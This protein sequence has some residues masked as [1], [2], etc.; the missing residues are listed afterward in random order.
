MGVRFPP[1]YHADFL[2]VASLPAWM[3]LTRSGT[4]TAF[5]S[6]GVLASVSADTPR[7]DY[8]PSTSTLRGLLLEPARTQVAVYTHDF[9][10]V[11]YWSESTSGAGTITRTANSGVAPDGTTTAALLEFYRA[12]ATEGARIYQTFTTTTAAWTGSYYVKA[13][14]AGDIGREL[15]IVAY[16]G[17]TKTPKSVI[18]TS[19]WQRV[20]DTQSLTAGG[21]SNFSIGFQPSVGS[22]TG[23]TKCYMTYA[24]YEEGSCITSFIPNTATSGTVARGADIATITSPALTVLQGT[25]GSAIVQFE[26]EGDRASDPQHILVDNS[27]GLLQLDAS[28]VVKTTDGTNVLSSGQTAVVGTAGRAGVAWNPSGRSISYSGSAA[29]SDANTR[30]S[31]GTA[32]LGNNNGSTAAIGWYQSV[33]IYDT[34]LSDSDLAMKTTVDGPY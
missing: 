24:Q 33:G 11:T 6:S 2:A 10:N 26:L 13:Y 14:A 23:T 21:S 8:F 28:L 30:G 9:S 1:V 22:E 32:Y 20:F 12:S 15:H 7:F 25:T 31:S 18:L 17:V 29:Q 19:S 34:R 16:D 3:T 5:N 27:I 4:A